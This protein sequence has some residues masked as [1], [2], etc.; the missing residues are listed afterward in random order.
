MPTEHA[1][2]A[3]RQKK[4]K[5]GS[6]KGS[7]E[8]KSGVNGWMGPCLTSEGVQEPSLTWKWYGH[9][10]WRAKPLIYPNSPG[11]FYRKLKYDQ[12]RV[13]S[14][15]SYHEITQSLGT[16]CQTCPTTCIICA[17]FW[18]PLLITFVSCFTYKHTPIITVVIKY[19]FYN[20]PLEISP[21][22][23]IRKETKRNSKVQC[24]ANTENGRISD[25]QY[26]QTDQMALSPV[27][28]FKKWRIKDKIIVLCFI[29]SNCHFIFMLLIVANIWS[30]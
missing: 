18:C 11:G 25:K 27:P 8:H 4:G 20:Q 14:T 7:S 30:P 19:P 29:V 2:R 23:Y 21:T 26:R 10:C 9:R 28:E 16:F 12:K 15:L 6:V 17:P 3:E 5:S 13:V 22:K 1:I 24:W